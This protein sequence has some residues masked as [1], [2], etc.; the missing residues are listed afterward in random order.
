MLSVFA[1][2]LAQAGK[3]AAGKKGPPPEKDAWYYID[4]V[5]DKLNN[6][7]F[8]A[9]MSSPVFWGVSIAVMILALFRGWKIVLIGYPLLLIMWAVVDKFITK[10]TTTGAG[11]SNVMVFAALTVGVAG[12]GIYFFLIRD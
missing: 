11:D 3:A 6:P 5:N 8:D 7:D 12:I 1:A 2:L 10:T 9:T 4:L